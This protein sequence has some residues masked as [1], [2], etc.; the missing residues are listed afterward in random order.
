[1]STGERIGS[2]AVNLEDLTA[3]AVSAFPALNRF[4]QRLSLELYRLLSGGQPVP[5]ALLAERLQ[6]SVVTVDRILDDWPGVF[7]DSER[8]IVGYWGLSIATAYSSPHQFTIDGQKLSAWCAW[9][10]FFLPQLLGKPA[11]VESRSPD[12]CGTVKLI[13]TPAGVDRVEPQ[14][15]H[16]SFLMPDAAGVQKDILT[17]FCHFVHFFPSRLR[18][19]AWAA[20]H[21]GTFILSVAEAHEIARRKNEA[22]YGGVLG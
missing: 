4:E 2:R 13:V 5:R 11:D 21:P 19:E 15:A 12:P 20:R 16:V 1:M 17:T 7:S 3:G 22:Q 8:R 18:G 14:D 10:T 6:S 9:D